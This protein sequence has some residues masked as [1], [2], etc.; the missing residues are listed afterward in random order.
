VWSEW[1]DLPNPLIKNWHL[2]LRNVSYTDGVL[3]I[4]LPESSSKSI[5]G[6]RSQYNLRI[7]HSPLQ[8]KSCSTVEGR[9]VVHTYPGWS[10]NPFLTNA[11]HFN[12][13]I[14]N[15]L[16]LYLFFV[17]NK[18]PGLTNDSMIPNNQLPLSN[19]LLLLKS[20]V[21]SDAKSPVF[22]FDVIL[23]FA[24]SYMHYDDY[25][26][27]IKPSTTHCFDSIDVPIFDLIDPLHPEKRPPKAVYG[28]WDTMHFSH[29]GRWGR[30]DFYYN[31]WRN[32]KKQIWQLYDIPVLLGFQQDSAAANVAANA[33]TGADASPTNSSSSSSNSISDTPTRPKIAFM[34][35]SGSNSPR[36][37]GNIK[38]VKSILQKDFDVTVFDQGFYRWHGMN[39]TLRFDLT[40]KTLL[41]VQA[42][43]IM[44]GQSGSN[45]QL[46]LFM[47]ENKMIVEIKNYLYCA[48]EGG[49]ALANHN[50]LAF[51]TI[52][53][54]DLTFPPSK[55]TPLHYQPHLVT[56]LS[57]ELLAAWSSIVRNDMPERLEDS[58]PAR[59][60]FLWPHQDPAILAKTALMTRSNVSRC[61]LEQVPGQGW[62][63]L[64]KHKNSLAASCQKPEEKVGTVV[65]YCMLSGLC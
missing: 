31:F 18:L 51:H 63:Q 22:L 33:G 45:N 46:A 25:F 38:E 16:F 24:S 3:N 49:K 28:L 57:G 10:K 48:N 61:Y 39:D 17:H 6:L 62:Y 21:R 34:A 30:K 32:V 9:N 60:D 54:T 59:C 41:R 12:I 53:A 20:E 35:R 55:N 65:I 19:T 4:H 52:K 2:K 50:R 23:R 7:V 58:W 56:K 26:G 44:L 5:T 29:A 27:S 15:P 1:E 8:W 40:R 11:G 36:F 42:T 47:R 14:L 37:D 64:A 13:N 43:D